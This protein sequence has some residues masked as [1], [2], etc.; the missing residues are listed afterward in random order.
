MQTSTK[1]AAATA[2]K[3]KKDKQVSP[4][5]ATA[6]KKAKSTSRTTMAARKKAMPG[7]AAPS[8]AGDVARQ[9]EERFR[10]IGGWRGDVLARMR[11]LIRGADPE[12]VEE[13]KW[14]KPS[15]P[16][17]V[18]TYSR[19][20]LVLTLEV[21]KEYVKVTFAYGSKVPD[22]T[23]IFNASLLGLRR[24]IDIRAGETVDEKAFQALVRAAVAVNLAKRN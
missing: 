18:P 9:I 6:A 16:F 7:A 2:T 11:A 14:V 4:K 5:R 20:G 1:K 8:N 10:E 15:N 17:G 12:L 13:R 21:Y 24:A 3:K 23:G 22:P 19:G